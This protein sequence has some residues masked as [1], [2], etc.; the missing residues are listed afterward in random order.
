MEGNLFANKCFEPYIP[1]DFLDEEYEDYDPL[2][3][4]EENGLNEGYDLSL[5]QYQEITMTTQ[6][7]PIHATDWVPDKED[8]LKN[9]KITID[10][11]RD[12]VWR[13]GKAEIEMLCKFWGGKNK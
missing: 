5:Q 11:A 7:E 8:D 6:D 10:K 9:I 12:L 13:Q 1:P 3:T 4:P 2:Y